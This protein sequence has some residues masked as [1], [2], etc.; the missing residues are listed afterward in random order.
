[1]RAFD[2]FTT[3]RL[4]AER[5]RASDFDDVYHMNQIPEVMRLIGGVRSAAATRE[6]VQVNLEHWDRHG[7]GVWMLR[8]PN[9]GALLGRSVLRSTKVE[10]N[11]ET[12]FGYALLPEYWGAGLATEVSRAILQIAFTDLHFETVVALISALN[13]ASRRVTEKVGG[14]YERDVV[15]TGAT[16]GLYRVTRGADIA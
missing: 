1:M 6:Y 9:D 3:E 8:N 11:D 15:H 12:E 13:S 14:R 16:L 7:F 10:G 2:R 4:V 5:L